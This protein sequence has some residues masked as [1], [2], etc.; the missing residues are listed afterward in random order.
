MVLTDQLAVRD[1]VALGAFALMPQDSLNLAAVL[2]GPLIGLNGQSFL[3]S[4]I[5]ATAPFGHHCV[6]WRAPIQNVP[7]LNVS[8]AM[9]FLGLTFPSGPY[10]HLA[11]ILGPMEGRALLLARLRKEANDPI[12]EFLALALAFEQTHTPSLQ[13]F[14]RWL[15]EG[16]AG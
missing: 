11:H 10:D 9:Y 12:D 15:E 4:A 13:G 1:L 5:S 7:R 16:D 2:K 6:V 14:L 8:L 3:K